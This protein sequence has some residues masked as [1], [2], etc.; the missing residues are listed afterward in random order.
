M[1]D[2]FDDDFDDLMYYEVEMILRLFDRVH[3]L[4]DI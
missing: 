2:I 3:N 4:F 1:Y